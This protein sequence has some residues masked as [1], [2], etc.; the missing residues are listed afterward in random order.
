MNALVTALFVTVV[1]ALIVALVWL[2]VKAI[3]DDVRHDA[4]YS[5]ENLAQ[6]LAQYG[7]REQPPRKA[8]IHKLAE[9]ARYKI[10]PPIDP[11][12]DPWRN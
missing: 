4:H 1:A 2:I 3:L 6:R 8:D 11:D 7:A 12:Y 9:A 5:E 10:E